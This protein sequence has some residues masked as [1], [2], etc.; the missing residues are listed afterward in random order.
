M[1]S[2][3]SKKISLGITP[4]FLKSFLRGF[5]AFIRRYPPRIPLEIFFRNS[6]WNYGLEFPGD[7]Q[8]EFVRGFSTEIPADII[9]KDPSE[10]FQKQ[11]L[12]RFPLGICLGIFSKNSSGNCKDSTMNYF[13]PAIL[14]AISIL[15]PGIPPTISP[16]ITSKDFSGYL[17]HK[18]FRRFYSKN[19]FE[20]FPQEYLWGFRTEFLLISS[21]DFF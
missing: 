6:F 4:D 5:Q 18:I 13:F 3:N 14:Q 2:R 12:R 9:S 1:S 20:D 19:P 8:R 7:F 15:F 16:E 17:L 21:G 11:F 10:D